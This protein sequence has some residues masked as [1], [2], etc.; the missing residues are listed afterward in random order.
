MAEAIV[1]AP[2]ASG[3]LRRV[4]VEASYPFSTLIDWPG[5]PSDMTLRSAVVLRVIR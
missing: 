4:R 2:A 5:I 3:R 1:I